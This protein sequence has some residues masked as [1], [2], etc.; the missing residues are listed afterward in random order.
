MRITGTVLY[1]HRIVLAPG[2]V[3][4]VRLEDVSR[5]DATGVVAE[6]TVVTAGEQ[7]PIPFV[8]RFERS[9]AEPRA[10]YGLSATIE[11]DGAVRFA[12]AAPMPMTTADDLENVELVVETV[13]ALPVPL[14]G[15]RWTLVELE[16]AAI[17]LGADE[18]APHL[19]LDAQESRFAGSGGCNRLSGGFTLTGHSLRFDTPITTLMA[20]SEAVMRREEAFVRALLRTTR[21]ALN[22]STLTLLRG[23]VVVARL[24]SE[25]REATDHARGGQ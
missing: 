5:S 8:L 20:C 21:Y 15:T 24:A 17:A 4:R 10:R 3:V 16:G 14:T 12:T 9:D 18:R 7:V 23:D 22:G 2:A 11:L 25:Q 1:R 6:T 19:A 13:P